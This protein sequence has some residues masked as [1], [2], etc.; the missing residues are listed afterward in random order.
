MNTKLLAL[1]L[2][3]AAVISAPAMAN[4]Y[5]VSCPGYVISLSEDVAIE[6]QARL[7][8]VAGFEQAVC[9]R[10]EGAADGLS[11]PTVTPVFIEELQLATRITVFPMNAD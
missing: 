2:A 1:S 7:G 8:T 4:T 3:S 6:G 9:A 5:M 11:G 10:S